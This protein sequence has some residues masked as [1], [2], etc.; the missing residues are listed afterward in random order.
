VNVRLIADKTT[1]CE[2]KTG[3]ELLAQAG[4]SLWI[5][6]GVRTAHAKTMV[7]D[8]RVTLVGSMNW[9]GGAAQNS[10]NLNLVVSPEVAETYAAH[11]RQRLAAS[12]PYAGRGEWCRAHTAGGRLWS[13]FG[14]W[15]T[16]WIVGSWTRGCASSMRS[17][18]PSKRL[19]PMGVRSPG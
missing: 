6:R 5:D 14:A 4:A 10:E 7:I 11:W 15:S 17:A 16:G 8:G 19:R 13:S 2:R 1:P 18:G 9:S 12:V 3:L